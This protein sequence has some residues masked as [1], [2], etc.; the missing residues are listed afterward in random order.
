MGNTYV[1]DQSLNPDILSWSPTYEPLLPLLP[2]SRPPYMYLHNIILPELKSSLD[3][4]KAYASHSFL[5]KLKMITGWK[6]LSMIILTI[7][8]QFEGPE[9]NPIS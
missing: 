3:I 8:K 9:I 7:L 2:L 6:F 4:C 1:S 5:L